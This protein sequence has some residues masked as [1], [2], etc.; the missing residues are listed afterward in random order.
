VAR[1]ALGPLPAAADP[2]PRAAR[3][4]RQLAAQQVPLLPG[5]VGAVKRRPADAAQSRERAAA[6]AV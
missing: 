4:K 6:A 3:P 2:V 5:A 1:V